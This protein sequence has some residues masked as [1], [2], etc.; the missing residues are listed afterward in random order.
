VIPEVAEVVREKAARL[1]RSP[2]V[3][4]F[5]DARNRVLYV[6]KAA[7]LRS[8][9][10]QYLAGSD[11]RRQV[12]VFLARSRDL[13]FQVTRTEAEALLLENTLIK[14]HRPHWNVRLRDDKAYPCLRLDTTHRFPRFTVVRRFR[15]DGALYFGP[16]AEAGHLRRAMRALR[17]VYPL[18]SCSD[19]FLESRRRGVRR[20]RGR[21]RLHVARGHGGAPPRPSTTHGGGLRGHA[22]RGGRR[23]P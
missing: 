8:R 19:S 3:Y 14:R 6:G 12:P 20:P 18:R 13:D 17:A 23:V 5:L 4:L 1:P 16:F 7:D 10:R 11:E 21:G 15:D 22:I 9:V 2:G